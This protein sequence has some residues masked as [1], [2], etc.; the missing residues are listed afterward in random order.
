MEVV[1]FDGPTTVLGTSRRRSFT[2]AVRRAIQV[3]DRHCQH[4][5][6]C[7][8]PADECDI[9]HIIPW[10]EGGVTDQFNGRL[11]CSTHNRHPDRHDHDATPIPPEQIT[12]LRELRAR[13]RWEYLHSQRMSSADDDDEPDD[14]GHPAA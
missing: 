6:G 7:D 4:P 5:S 8:T 11:Q 2:G 9:D 1:L 10:G 12:I 3:R 13:L 14:L